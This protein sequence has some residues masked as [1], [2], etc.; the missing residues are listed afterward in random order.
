MRDCCLC[1]LLLFSLGMI[2]W[3]IKKN[4]D[5]KKQKESEKKQTQLQRIK[6]EKEIKDLEAEIEFEE[7]IDHGHGDLRI[8]LPWRNH[9]T[10]KPQC[11]TGSQQKRR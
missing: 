4:M 1:L 7:N 9:D 11:K 8:F 5:D 3:F 10:Q 2:F 6:L